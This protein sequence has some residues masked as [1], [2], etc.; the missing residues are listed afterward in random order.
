MLG[1]TDDLA[2]VGIKGAL[3][4]SID[5]E[6]SQIRSC[7]EGIPHPPSASRL[8]RSGHGSAAATP[9]TPQ[10]LEPQRR[11]SRLFESCRFSFKEP[12][13]SRVADRSETQWDLVSCHPAHERDI[14]AIRAVCYLGKKRVHIIKMT[15]QNRRAR[16]C[17]G[18]SMKE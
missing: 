7:G 18:K 16:R 12:P 3:A 2:A 8:T 4:L 11:G 17:Y 6:P 1:T 13:L 10:L 14:R 15:G 5:T 9:D